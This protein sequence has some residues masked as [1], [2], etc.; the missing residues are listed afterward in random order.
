[1]FFSLGGVSLESK[2]RIVIREE[3]ELIELLLKDRTTRKNIIWATDSYTKLGDQYNPTDQIKPHLVTNGAGHLIKPRSE[4]AIDE[5]KERTKI[6][7]EVYTP[8]WVVKKQNDLVEDEFKDLS[9]KEYIN[10]TWLE[11]TCGEAPYMCSRYDM[12]TGES[13]PIHERVGFVDRKIQRISKEIDN[14]DD[15]LEYVYKAYKSSYGYEFQGDSLLIAR[16]NLVYTFIEYY[17]EKFNNQPDFEYIKKIT[18][19]VSYN[20]FQ[21][22]GLTYTI[23]MSQALEMNE[24]EI[25]LDLFGNFETDGVQLEMEFN[26]GIK[27]KIERYI[28]NQM[29]QFEKLA[30]YEGSNKMK[31]D[32][33][34]GNPPYQENISSHS[35]NRSL[36]KQ[37]FPSF[38]MESTK[39]TNN[40]VSLITPAKWFSSQGQDHSFPPLRKFAKENNHFK[41]IHYFGGDAKLFDDVELGAVSYFL[42]DNT[43][44]GDTLFVNYNNCNGIT[45]NEIKRPLFE[46]DIDIILALNS[47]VTI[48]KK[49]KEHSSFRSL[50]QITKGRDAFNVTGKQAEKV[51]EEKPFQG[52]YELRCAYEVIRYISPEK[53][54]KNKKIADSWKVLIS[55]AN[56]GAGL[57]SDDKKVAIIGVPYIGKPKSISTD[58]LIP[59]GSFDS[60]EEAVN[61]KK[62][63]HTKFVR[64]MIGV[65]K[66]SQNLYQNVYQFVPMQD[67]TNESDLNWSLGI[68]EIDKQ[69]YDKYGLNKE[70][71]EFIEKK[72]KELEME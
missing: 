33:V 44:N 36:A 39:I 47:S 70:E 16:E 54:N 60:E 2:D 25:Q 11:I 12:V 32:V 26:K 35:G 49:I 48:L 3:P 56:G 20:A 18:G 15:W 34:I 38:I 37:L 8:T 22:D 64:H 51:S 59:I 67:F 27:V 13:I 29:L 28:N 6:K 55:K 41:Q 19:I 5:Q 17:Y 63:L 66:T 21:M 24:P 7:A 40:Y 9:L 57:L 68:R 4:K 58:S 61:L 50:T 46:N 62:Y 45:K 31:F 14:H 1:M 53:I 42:Y 10:K 52:A 30:I 65:M 72:I 43:Y 69:L 23:P 71:T